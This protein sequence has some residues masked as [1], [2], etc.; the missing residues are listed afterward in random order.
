MLLKGR[1]RQQSI[2]RSLRIGIVD[3]GISQVH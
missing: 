2:Y 1:H 3:E